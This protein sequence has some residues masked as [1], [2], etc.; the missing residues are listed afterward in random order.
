MLFFQPFHDFAHVLG[1]ITGAN[2][3][4]VGRLN[5]DQVAHANRGHEF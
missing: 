4:R 2:E 5:D 3:Q 1:A